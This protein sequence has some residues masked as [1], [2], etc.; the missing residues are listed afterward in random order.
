MKYMYDDTGAY[1]GCTLTPEDFPEM[2]FTDITTPVYDEFD[3]V[4]FFVDGA[5]EI[6][7]K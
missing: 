4:L 2:N 5:W 7:T 1:Q 6:R 3:E